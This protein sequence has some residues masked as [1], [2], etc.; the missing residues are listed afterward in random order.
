MNQKAK[1]GIKYLFF[2]I[3]VG[4]V[5]AGGFTGTG[6]FRFEGVKMEGVKIN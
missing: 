3:F 1:Q 6:N 5:V 4:A 2:Y